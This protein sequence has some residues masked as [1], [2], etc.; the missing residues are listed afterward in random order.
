MAIRRTYWTDA[1]CARVLQLGAE[2][3]RE[4]GLLPGVAYSLHQLY[5]CK[6][7][8]TP[9]LKLFVCLLKVLFYFFSL[10]DARKD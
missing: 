5:E 9:L 4:Q 6:V 8:F 10:W 2:A 3:Q 1:D 7:D